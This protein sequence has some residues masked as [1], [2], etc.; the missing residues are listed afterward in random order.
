MQGGK[1]VLGTG[2]V[3]SHSDLT[4]K[5]LDLQKE[6]NQSSVSSEKRNKCR[7]GHAR[8]HRVDPEI[9]PEL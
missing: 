8:D 1:P 3:V 5:D 7:A 4:N 9:H 2:E 6:W